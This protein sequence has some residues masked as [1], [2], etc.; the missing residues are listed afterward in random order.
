LLRFSENK[1]KDGYQGKKG[2]RVARNRITRKIGKQHKK[3][4]I[5]LCFGEGSKK[6]TYAKKLAQKT[7]SLEG[8][9]RGQTIHTDDFPWGACLVGN[10]VRGN[11]K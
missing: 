11:M 7:L 1:R 8:K 4:L 10:T 2:R 6:T 5:K 9:Q 3:N